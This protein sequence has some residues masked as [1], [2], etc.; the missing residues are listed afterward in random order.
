MRERSASEKL[1]SASHQ[2][3]GFETQKTANNER[4][5]GSTSSLHGF[6]V[7]PKSRKSEP[8]LATIGNI[9]NFL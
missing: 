8:F 9:Q 3:V 4:G 7:Y 5:N 1:N 6:L 2:T